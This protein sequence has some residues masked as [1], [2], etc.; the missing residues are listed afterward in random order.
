LSSG[1][2]FLPAGIA[3]ALGVAGMVYLGMRDRSVPV[4]IDPPQEVAEGRKPEARGPLRSPTSPATDDVAAPDGGAAAP[5]TR[6]TTSAPATTG[7]RDIKA[8]LRAAGQLPD[9]TPSP[10]SATNE[11]SARRNIAAPSPGGSRGGGSP[12]AGPVSGGGGGTR[13]GSG[14]TP[15]STSP[16]SGGAGAPAGSTYGTPPAGP[17]TSQPTTPSSGNDSPSTPPNPPANDPPPPSPPFDDGPDDPDPI[18]DPI[19]DSGDDDSEDDPVTPAVVQMIPSAE[20]VLV[21]QQVTVSVQIASGTDVGHVP[22]HLTFDP[23]VLSFESGLEGQFLASDGWQ[24]VFFA[25]PATDGNRIVVGLSR[26]GA[27]EGIDG[28]GVLCTLIFSAIGP[29]NAQLGFQSQ[30]VKDS[31]NRVVPSL[32]VA[33]SVI[34]E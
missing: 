30:K 8:E 34:V 2:V 7:P 16:S 33:G 12:A 31:Q 10:S 20:R 22:F 3:L 5:T 29:G 23:T 15:S 26:L 1:K 25:S 6:G 11:P 32:F 18:D 13:S 27:A 9:V 24:T 17:P 28:G 21:G 4:P 14:S 19:D